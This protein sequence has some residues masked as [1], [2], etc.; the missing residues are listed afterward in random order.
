MG[1]NDLV[2]VQ[3]LRDTRGALERWNT[4]PWPVLRVWFGGALAVAS[5]LLLAVWAVAALSPADLTRLSLPGLTEEPGVGDVANILFRNSLVLALH[6][7]ACV[8]GFIAGSSLVIS[9]QGRS[10]LSKLVHEKARPIAFAWVTLVTCFSLITQAYALGLTG[11]QLALQL[12]VSP[13]VLVLTTLPH[14]IPEL[15]ALFLPLAAWTIAS[16][17]SEWKDLLA[18]TFATVAI[19]IPMLVAAAV[20]ET[21]VWPH[22]LIAVSPY[23]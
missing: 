6:A 23:A 9:A 12:G 18:A 3:G 19:A 5:A 14:A 13:G 11:A 17:R 8:A 21:Y 16:R 20:W 22:I 2:V 7:F 15:V 4:H 1:V 10:G